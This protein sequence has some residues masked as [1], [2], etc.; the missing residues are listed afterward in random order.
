M[1]SDGGIFTFGGMPFCGSTGGTRLN[2]PVVGMAM[3][4][5]VGGY[6]EVAADGGIFAFGGAGFYGSMGGRPLNQPDRGHGRHPRR[7]AATGRWPP[8]AA[9]SPSATPASSAPWAGTPLNQ[10]IVG[11]S[12]STDGDGYRLVASDGGI[13]AFGDAPFSGSMGGIRLNRPVV[14]MTNDTNTGGYWEVAS[15]GGVFSFGG[16]PFYGSTGGD[17]PQCA[18]R[19]HGRDLQRERLPVRRLRRGRLQPSPPPSSGRW[20]AVRLNRPMVGMAGF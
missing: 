18:H 17:P 9:S 16:A 13:F 3:A 8:T 14:G 5:A 6:W 2:A 10:P 19:G 4:P 1:A 11:M 12:S 15:D 20:A 7:P